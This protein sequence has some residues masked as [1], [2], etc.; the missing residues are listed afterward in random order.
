MLST[1]LK[2][3]PLHFIVRFVVFATIFVL[4]KTLVATDPSSDLPNIVM[5][6]SDDQGM[7]DLSCYGGEFETPNLD[8]LA[9]EGIRLTQFYAASSICTPSRY[10]LF[11]GRYAHRS[12]D[13]LTGALMFLAEEDSNRGLRQSEVT[14]AARLKQFGYSTSLVGKWHLGHGNKEFWPTRHGF[15]SF[16]GHTGGCIDFHTLRYGN[17]LDWYRDEVIETPSG[18]ATDVITGEAIE[19]LRRLNRGHRPFYLHLSYN[20][21]HFGKAWD[22]STEKPVNVMQPKAEDLARVNGAMTPLRQSFAAKVIGLDEGVGRVL[23]TLDELNLTHNTI[24]I[25]MTD[26][27]G[28]PVYGGSNLPYRGGKATLYEGGIRVPCIVRWP[29]RIEAARE[30]NQVACA[31]D[32][33]ATFMDLCG[34]EPNPDLDGHSLLPLLTSAD[35]ASSDPTRTLVWKTGAHKELMRK[36]WSAV[37]RGDWKWIRPPNQ[38]AELYNVNLD[39]CETNNLA[40]RHPDLMAELQAIGG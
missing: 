1:L 35:G 34:E 28:D 33:F 21:P 26:H 32:W 24:V 7:H 19:E 27:G 20:A 9:D 16:F 37:R 8:Q 3:N 4:S 39:P 36:S 31:V 29:S 17:R 12:K 10:G 25:F 11:T 22:A 2:I 18:Y 5:I 15:A 6:F 23:S 40:G 13:Q 38:E 30:S 14:Y